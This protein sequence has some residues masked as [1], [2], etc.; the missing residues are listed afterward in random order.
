MKKGCREETRKKIFVKV[1]PPAAKMSELV[2][3]RNMPPSGQFPK[4][5]PI[6]EFH[7]ILFFAAKSVTERPQK[8]SLMISIHHD[9]TAVRHV[10]NNEFASKNAIFAKKI[11][12]WDAASYH[13]ENGY[14]NSNGG[15]VMNE[16]FACTLRTP[17]NG[18]L[19]PWHQESTS[20]LHNMM[21]QRNSIAALQFFPLV[22]TQD[23]FE[24]LCSVIPK[25]Q[26]KEEEPRRG[27]MSKDAEV[28]LFVYSRHHRFITSLSLP[29]F[30]H[31]F[32]YKQFIF[33][34]Q[35]SSFCLIKSL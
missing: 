15:S 17:R 11:P 28:T 14:L 23:F 6:I 30:T 18:A 13:L 7:R 12:Y 10:K 35:L 21:N 31:I 1:A 16:P 34:V 22:T 20:P 29:F 4:L 33:S 24:G 8:R 19:M 3:P 5:G 32:I 26:W 9:T 27:G 25:N 2:T